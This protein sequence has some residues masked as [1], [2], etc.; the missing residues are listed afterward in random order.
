[1]RLGRS[2]VTVSRVGLGTAPLAGLYT[3]V[4]EE[5]AA[6]TLEAAW[7]AG[8]RYFDTAPR[9]GEGLAERRLGRFLAGV[10]RAAVTVSSK[11]GALLDPVR[12]DYTVEGVY[13]SLVGSLERTGLDAFDLL[14]IHDPDDHWEQ[15]VRYAYPAL[16]RLRAQGGVR[17]IGV[18][19]NQAAMPARFVRET[20]VDCVMVAGRYSL[21]DRTAGD[22]LLPLCAE[23]GVGVLVAGVFNGGILADPTPGAH[24]DYRP[25]SE[26]VLKRA[27][28]MAELCE[29]HGVPLA[30]AALRFPLRHPAVTGVVVGARSP[31]EVAEDMTLAATTIPDA[32]WAELEAE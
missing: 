11:V 4:G 14:L 32:L 12:R 27:R 23:R 3:P 29:A 31:E 7:D 30:A 16:E 2:G 25:A 15:A 8:V 1:M 6:A 28:A 9:Y 21:L 24:Y 13:A 18:G 10:D 17:A 5:Q 19:M 26:P 20:D 22:E